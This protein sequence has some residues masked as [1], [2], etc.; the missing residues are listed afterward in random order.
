MTLKLLNI[1]FYIAETVSIYKLQFSPEE[2]NLID[3][4][5][6]ITY[7]SNLNLY[8]IG[9]LNSFLFGLIIGKIW[10]YFNKLYIG[11]L[12]LNNVN[13]Y[14]IKYISKRILNISL[15]WKLF[16]FLFCLF[17]LIDIY[18]IYN[19]NGVINFDLN[20]NDTILNMSESKNNPIIDAS[21]STINVNNPV[22][23][24]SIP[25]EAVKIATT[26][27]STAAGMKAGLE[28]SKNVP[29]I[30]AK[31]AVVTGTAIVAQA[32]NITANKILKST[33][34]TKNNF[35]PIN[36]NHFI[37]EN[38][39]DSKIDE[40][41]SDYPFNLIPDLNMYIN[42][43]IWFLI[44]LSNVL[45]TTYLLDKK[46]DINEFITNEKMRKLLNFM[47]NRYISVWSI[48]KNLIIIWCILMLFVCIFMS[49]LILTILLSV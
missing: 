9:L 37:N 21:K 27:I 23:N 46:I 18:Q 16:I 45:L 28:L 42:I 47:Y 17:I 29:G 35:I 6:I 32:I 10:L 44:I 43:E 13:I 19:Y 14:I 2:C 24:V 38:V 5:N 41:Y 1:K 7:I 48:S 36:I 8:N 25:I 33:S 39:N 15:F 4:K 3:N 12:F 49:K 11:K 20:L 30:G 26:S 40:K 34:N 31:A 22:A